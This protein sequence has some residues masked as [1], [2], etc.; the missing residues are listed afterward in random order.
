M[1]LLLLAAAAHAAPSQATCQAWATKLKGAA[2]ATLAGLSNLEDPRMQ[3]LRGQI[4]PGP[5]LAKAANGV[6]RIQ[7]VATADFQATLALPAGNGRNA[8][9][10]RVEVSKAVVPLILEVGGTDTAPRV[11][12]ST[13]PV[14]ALAPFMKTCVRGE[15]VKAAAV[16]LAGSW[17]KEQQPTWHRQLDV[18]LVQ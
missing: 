12:S 10:C 5:V 6:C 16:T 14:E 1:S 18:W 3:D 17:V 7:T 11:K 13:L 2:N 15:W 8:M 9:S 4:L